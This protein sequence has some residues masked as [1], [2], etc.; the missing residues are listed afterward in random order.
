MDCELVGNTGADGSSEGT[1]ALGATLTRC[2]VTG[3][4][5]VSQGGFPS[6]VL[7]NATLTDC[8]V[9]EN[10]VVSGPSATD[11][12][13]VLLHCDATR[14]TI[15]RASNSRTFQGQPFLGAAAFGCMLVECTIEDCGRGAHPTDG[16]AATGSTLVRCVL[17][18][19]GSGEGSL[20]RLSNIENCTAVD[21]HYDAGW[22]A[23]DR[24]TAVNSI[25]TGNGPEPFLAGDVSWSCLD[26][27]PAMSG[28]L[29]MGNL[30]ADPLLWS[31]FGLDENL[32]P[33]S[34]CIDR[35]DPAL[36]DAD[37]SRLDIG[38]IPFDAGYAPSPTTYCIPRDFFGIC[39]AG[40]GA[41]RHPSLSGAPAVVAAR[42]TTGGEFGLFFVARAPGF[43]VLFPQGVLC[44]GGPLQRS[45]IVAAGGTAGECDGTMTFAVGVAELTQFGVGA[46]DSLYLQAFFRASASGIPSTI[47][48]SDA[49]ELLVLP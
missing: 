8:L 16:A 26:V 20:L 17:R 21:N 46:G 37:G 14:T 40:I 5:A 9:E 28:S 22:S 35:G 18:R 43:S 45:P 29:G 1:A 3:H 27:D 47:G 33:G 48:L 6:G 12:G 23:F 25:L 4:A 36:M 32:R 11:A 34:P 19:N 24:V 7:E 13:A 15:R 49:V 38:A 39:V 30:V 41:N 10:S 31:P 42:G 44:L 2:I